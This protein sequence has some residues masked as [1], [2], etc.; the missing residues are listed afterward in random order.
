MPLSCKTGLIAALLL[1]GASGAAVADDKPCAAPDQVLQPIMPTH[2]IPPYPEMSVMTN[3]EGTTLMEVL[4]GADGVPLQTKLVTSSGSLRLD[5]A[6]L[7]HV[8]NV[9]RWNP[10]TRNCQPMQ[11]STRISIK[12]DLRNATSAGPQPPTLVM[13]KADYPAGALARH[14]QG[15]VGLIVMV[16]ADGQVA[17]TRVSQSSGFPELDAKAQEIVKS[18]W[19]WTPATLDGKALNTVMFIVASWKI[20]VDGK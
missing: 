19:H 20:D 11:V 1:L 2:T 17:F 9:W 3:E 5:E 15:S 14:E 16:L 13:D 4:I 6:A 8:K 10:P 7:A 12:W 18:R